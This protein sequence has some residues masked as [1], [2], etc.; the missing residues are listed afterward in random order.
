MDAPQ[1]P[2]A[3]SDPVRGALWMVGS[4]VFFAILTGLIRY[5]SATLDPL[6]IVFFRNLFGMVAMLPWLMRQG[7][8]GLRTQHLT[9]HIVRAGLGLTAMTCAHK[10]ASGAPLPVRQ[11]ARKR[12]RNLDGPRARI[13]EAKIGAD[14]SQIHR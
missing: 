7:F 3:P 9:M 13:N 11:C 10:S 6:E 12:H 2:A 1:S 4:C 14:H 5:L 8:S